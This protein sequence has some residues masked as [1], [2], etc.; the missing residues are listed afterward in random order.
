[1]T[2]RPNTAVERDAPPASWLRAP[3]LERY[4]ATGAMK[5]LFALL[6]ALVTSVSAYAELPVA[7]EYVSIDCPKGDITLV[8]KKDGTFSLELK[9]WDPQ[10]Y[11]HGHSETLSGSWR[12][13]G[14]NLILS[15]SVEVNYQREPAAMTVGRYS[16]N[17]DGFRWLNSSKPT[18]VD[19]FTLVERKA[20]DTLLLR[21]AP[22]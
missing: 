22:K 11:R 12:L 3:H 17:I 14:K 9:H 21:A 6:V 18:F 20:T 4:V 10:Q 16:D 13:S 2:Y 8:L 5:H 19:T 7:S 1:M 15:G